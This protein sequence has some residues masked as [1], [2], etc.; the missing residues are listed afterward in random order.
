M[1]AIAAPLRRD[2]IRMYTDWRTL[3]DELRM[4]PRICD[5]ARGMFENHVTAVAVEFPL[6]AENDWQIHAFWDNAAAT[7]Y[8]QEAGILRK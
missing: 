8:L 1:T 2:R 6:D 7:R 5:S 3:S 4:V